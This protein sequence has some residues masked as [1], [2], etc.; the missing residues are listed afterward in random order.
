[1]D[2]GTALPLITWEQLPGKAHCALNLITWDDWQK[3]P[4]SDDVFET[5]ITGVWPF[6]KKK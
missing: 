3:M 2:G 1:M 6:D 5:L 4:L